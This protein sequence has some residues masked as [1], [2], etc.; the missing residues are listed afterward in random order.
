MPRVSPLSLSLMAVDSRSSTFPWDAGLSGCSFRAGVGL[1]AWAQS[2]QLPNQ[3][4]FWEL[5]WL[6]IKAMIRSLSSQS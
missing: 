2:Q 6:V 3:A 4:L 1:R 5:P